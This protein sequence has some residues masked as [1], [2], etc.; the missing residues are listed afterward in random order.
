MLGPQDTYEAGLI[1]NGVIPP[2]SGTNILTTNHK[3]IYI[4]IYIFLSRYTF[5]PS[6]VAVESE[7][8]LGGHLLSNVYLP[9]FPKTG[10]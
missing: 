10:F 9:P 4:Y 1:I 2:N 8:I 7:V 3:S 5:F 6:L